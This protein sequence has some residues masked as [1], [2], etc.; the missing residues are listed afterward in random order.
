MARRKNPTNLLPAN[1]LR[2]LVEPGRYSDGGGLYLQVRERSKS[3]LFV[4][5]WDRR[6]VEMGLGRAGNA[7]DDVS[8]AAAREAA[9]QARMRLDAG[10]NP[11][12][13][14]RSVAPPKT[15]PPTFGVFGRYGG[16]RA[17]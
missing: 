9:T 14:R 12:E 1:A 7:P 13:E 2:A 15:E 3:W 11:L 17:D 5:R 10:A 4:F 8:L 16:C 6:R